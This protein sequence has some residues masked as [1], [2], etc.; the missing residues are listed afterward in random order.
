MINPLIVRSKISFYFENCDLDQDLDAVKIENR[1]VAWWEA[2][3]RECGKNLMRSGS[4]PGKDPYYK[5]SK[6][7]KFQR[8]IYT[9]DL[10]QPNQHGFQTYYKKEYDKLEDENEAREKK[11]AEKKNK[12]DKELKEYRNRSERHLLKKVIDMEEEDNML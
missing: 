11:R 10:I 3:C 9:K 6:K 4:N 1:W 2:K 8:S 7:L 5:K 12:I